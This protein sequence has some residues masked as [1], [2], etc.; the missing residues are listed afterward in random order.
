ML[1]EVI[2]QGA[3]P[4]HGARGAAITPATGCRSSVGTV[5]EHHLAQDVHPRGLEPAGDLDPAVALRAERHGPGLE[6][7]VGLLHA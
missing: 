4:W 5:A 7:I 1:Y 2:T 3:G 6:E